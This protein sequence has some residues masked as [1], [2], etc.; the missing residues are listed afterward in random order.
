M[1]L[2]GECRPGGPG[3]ARSL[4]R[5]AEA[6][7]EISANSRRAGLHQTCTTVISDSPRVPVLVAGQGEMTLT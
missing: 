7:V 1:G 2:R 5:D 6:G 3:E 4:I